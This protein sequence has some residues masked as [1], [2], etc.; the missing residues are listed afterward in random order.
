[1]GVAA[2]LDSRPADASSTQARR[3]FTVLSIIKSFLVTVMIARK[4]F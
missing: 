1:M 2:A 4:S 3:D